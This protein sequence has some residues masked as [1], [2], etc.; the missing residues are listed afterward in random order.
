MDKNYGFHGHIDKNADYFDTMY[1]ISREGGV[2]M[3]NQVAGK[4]AKRLVKY[5]STGKEEIY[6]YGLEIIISTSCCLLS[7][8]LISCLLSSLASGLVFISVF[9]PLRLFTGGYHATTYSKCFVISNLIYLFTLFVKYIAWEKT[10]MELWGCLL[11][12][13]CCYIIKNAP[14]INSAQ[15]MNETRQKRSKRITKYILITDTIWIIYLALYQKE[16]MAMAIL[17]ICLVSAMMLIS[18]MNIL[19]ISWKGGTEW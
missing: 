16:W 13:M 12:I 6:I 9:V 14:V 4:L 1:L 15:P 3:L 8:L 10:P 17:S 19:T 7:I 2:D 11:F 18:K 5:S